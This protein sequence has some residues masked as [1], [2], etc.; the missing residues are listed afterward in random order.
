MRVT[1][2]LLS[3]FVY[4]FQYPCLAQKTLERDLKTYQV[5]IK[6][7]IIGVLKKESRLNES[8]SNKISIEVLPFCIFKPELVGNEDLRRFSIFIDTSFKMTNDSF[9]K[10]NELIFWKDTLYAIPLP[11]LG[12]Q[13]FFTNINYPDW[14]SIKGI[15]D[16]PMIQTA[17]KYSRLYFYLK[18]LNRDAE[19]NVPLAFLDHGAIHLIDR[20]L[21]IYSSIK[22]FIEIKYGCVDKYLEMVEDDET[23]IR[24]S[25]NMSANEAKAIFRNDFVLWWRHHP[26]DTLGVLNRFLDQ[27]DSIVKMQSGQRK[28]LEFK[29]KNDIGMFPT[30]T[31]SGGI[32]LF[33]R[34]A[35]SLILTVLTDNQYIRYI[36]GRND[37]GYLIARATDRLD[38]YY[39]IERKIPIEK[40]NEIL[41]NEVFGPR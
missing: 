37:A 1:Y 11:R 2:F 18:L 38:T 7:R 5:N 29:I 23:R 39:I 15:P 13:P 20:D 16:I 24:L 28:L 22:D 4:V 36:Q 35:S 31:C 34:Y 25:K 21:N 6:E 30:C 40:E 12:R 17:Q 9:T 3:L 10:I 14:F 26:T 19:G 33:D 27:M 32:V 41:N 8:D